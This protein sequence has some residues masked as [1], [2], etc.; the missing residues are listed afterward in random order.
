MKSETKA[1]AKCFLGFALRPSFITCR[2]SLFNLGAP[3]ARLQDYRDGGAGLAGAAGVD[4]DD[5]IL[6]V[7]PALLVGEHDFALERHPGNRPVAGRTLAYLDLVGDDRAAVGGGFP[8]EK[9]PALALARGL[10]SAR[11]A[12]DVG[13]RAGFAL[14]PADE[15][16]LVVVGGD[17]GFGVTV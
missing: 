11:D 9:N 4:R 14:V 8:V 16:Q 10:E 17:G 3:D 13:G 5:S 1:D 15:L 7:F 6:E 12:G 2:S